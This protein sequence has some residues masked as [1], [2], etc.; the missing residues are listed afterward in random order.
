[1][2]PTDRAS[3]I[4]RDASPVTY[5]TAQS[6]PVLTFHGD[7]DTV[8]KLEQ[9]IALH[10]ALRAAGVREKLV[11]VPGAGHGFDAKQMKLLVS[12]VTG[13]LSERL[14]PEARENR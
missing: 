5:I 6:P 14:Q 1:M 3:A 2:G 10:Q 9:S 11:I 4:L 13:F 12:H 8:V 7:K